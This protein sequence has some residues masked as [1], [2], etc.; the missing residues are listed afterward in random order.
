MKKQKILINA[1]N[2]YTGG[3][4][5]ISH[6][7]FDEI[8]KLNEYNFTIIAPKILKNQISF[9][10]NHKVIFF[11]YPKKKFNFVYKLFIDH[12]YIAK[13]FK[14]EK[15]DL[16]LNCGNF[17]SFFV[18][19]EKQLTLFHNIFYTYNF[20]QIKKYLNIRLILEI[21]LFKFCTN[22]ESFFLTQNNFVKKKLIHKYNLDRRRLF[23]VDFF[24]CIP[25]IFKKIKNFKITN[26]LKINKN[27]KNIIYPANYYPNKNFDK[28]YLFD[29]IISENKLNIKIFLTIKNIDYLELK[30]KYNLK[31]I[32]NLGQLKKNKIYNYYKKFDFVLNL[33]EFES[34]CLPLYEA[35]FFSKKIISVEADFIPLSFKKKI[36]LISGLKK[37]YI[38]TSLMKVIK[39]RNEKKIIYNDLSHD[40]LFSLNK[41]FKI[42]LNEKKYIN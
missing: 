28:L 23:V 15:F 2:L 7:I 8:D 30:K 35:I 20:E 27:Y 37:K 33:S 10:K 36:F 40:N 1:I 11:Q 29:E 17:S 14:K 25:L 34:M 18:N 4:Q 5:T 22:R 32:Y 24:K 21:F 13:K 31:N 41:I 6:Y 42:R 9:N 12:I 19:N 16:V 38:K 39:S 3:S 26:N